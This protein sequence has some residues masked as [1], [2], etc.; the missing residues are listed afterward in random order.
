MTHNKNFNSASL[1]LAFN[2]LIAKWRVSSFEGRNFDEK[3]NMLKIIETLNSLDEI[4]LKHEIK[5]LWN[6]WQST[7]KPPEK[8]LQQDSKTISTLN[9]LEMVSDF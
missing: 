5:L 7:T 4:R 1:T 3:K 6:A 2:L 8:Y 9:T